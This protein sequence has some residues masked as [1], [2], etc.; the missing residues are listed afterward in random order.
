MKDGQNG[1][2]SLRARSSVISL[3]L[4]RPRRCGRTDRE[5]SIFSQRSCVREVRPSL[6]GIG[7]NPSLLRA[8][9][10]GGLSTSVDVLEGV[11]VDKPPV[12]PAVLDRYATNRADS[13]PCGQVIAEPW[14]PRFSAPAARPRGPWRRSCGRGRGRRTRSAPAVV[15]RVRKRA[16]RPVPGGRP[17][18]PGGAIGRCGRRVRPDRGSTAAGTWEPSVHI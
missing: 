16:S 3:G 7:S 11:L 12:L 14:Y 5:S 6:N 13:W 18:R 2:K 1:R 17:R 9:G 4:S 15:G 8:D 10:T